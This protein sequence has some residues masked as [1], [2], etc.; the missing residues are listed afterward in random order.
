MTDLQTCLKLTFDAGSMETVHDIEPDPTGLAHLK[1]GVE[2]FDLR[3][4]DEHR[5]GRAVAQENR[6]RVNLRAWLC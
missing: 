6:R 4:V 5:A 2:A 1:A 3:A